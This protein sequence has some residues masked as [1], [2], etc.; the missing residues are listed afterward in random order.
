MKAL[1]K[2]KKNHQNHQHWKSRTDLDETADISLSILN[3]SQDHRPSLEIQACTSLKKIS[4]NWFLATLSIFL[5][6]R[7]MNWPYPAHQH[8][9]TIQQLPTFVSYHREVLQGEDGQSLIHQ[10]AAVSVNQHPTHQNFLEAKPLHFC[11]EAWFNI[12]VTVHTWKQH[13]T[14]LRQT[15]KSNTPVSPSKQKQDQKERSCA[16]LCRWCSGGK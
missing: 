7:A 5:P 16:V 4:L 3:G 13:K 12:K 8:T 2:K 11:L 6:S 1:I 10:S 14:L 9:D 15:G